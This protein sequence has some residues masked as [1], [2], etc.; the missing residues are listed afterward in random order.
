MDY[1]LFILAVVAI[2]AWWFKTRS[3]SSESEIKT[4]ETRTLSHD[5]VIK[6]QLEFERR[7]ESESDL[8]DGIRGRD[9]YIYWNLMRKWFDKLAAENRY[10]EETFNKLQ[11]DWC[12]Y[13]ELL[14]QMKSAR[15]MAM[16][17]EDQQKATTYDQEAVQAARSIEAI[18]DAFAALIGHEATETLRSIRDLAAD[19]FDRTGKRDVAPPGHHYFPVSI[20]PYIEECKPKPTTDAYASA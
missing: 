11:R 13:M 18:Q 4:R 3:T 1:L 16:E 2:T 9:A 10:T 5:E 8:P 7:L 14:P 19:A 6:S 20:S 12:A 17:L 15:F